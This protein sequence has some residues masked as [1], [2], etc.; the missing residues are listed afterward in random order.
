MAFVTGKGGVGKSTVSVA[1][2]I[3]AARTGR[4]VTLCA[5]GARGGRP[6]ALPPEAEYVPLLP[7]DAFR[8]WLTRK[9]GR[10]AATL[11][12]RSE[13]LASLIAAAP[14]ARELTTIGKAWDLGRRP[15]HP[16]V[17][18]DGPSTG[19]ALALL[20][21]PTTFAALGG[22]GPIGHEARAVR[23]ALRDATRT[24]LVVVATPAEL[25][26]AE[27]LDLDRG[28]RRALGRGTD[29]LVVNDVLEDRFDAREVAALRAAPHGRAVRAALAWQ[30]RR[31]AQ[32]AALARLAALKPG[33]R[34]DL[35][36]VDGA[37]LTAADLDR[38]AARL[39]VPQPSPAPPVSAY[40]PSITSP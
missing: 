34:I 3:A 35:P 13:A 11:L 31:D 38:L 39:R 23:D 6:D 1:L 19:H 22:P 21:A 20:R 17:V 14:G 24:L 4:P 25:P 36:H 5:I 30:D 26:V 15:P 16:L 7:D 27:T 37:A 9:V 18:V 33:V 28:L 40:S 10:P 32:Q 8:E 29:V 2:A 12:T